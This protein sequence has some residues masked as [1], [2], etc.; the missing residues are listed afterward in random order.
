MVTSSTLVSLA[1]LIANKGPFDTSSLE[2]QMT[3][4][5]QVK[6]TEIIDSGACLPEKLEMLLQKS[7]NSPSP[8]NKS[9]DSPSEGCYSPDR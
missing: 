7:K 4:K 6:V 9:V 2:M 5:E 8:G 3:T 1:C